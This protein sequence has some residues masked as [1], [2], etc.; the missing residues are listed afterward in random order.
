MPAIS[1]LHR[2]RRPLPGGLG[3]GTSAVSADHLD[4][5]VIAQP[6]GQRR[7]L[8]VGQQ[9][10]RAA[11]VDVDQDGA[12]VMTPAQRE[13]IDAK[14]RQP[15]NRRVGQA[16]QQPYQGIAAGRHTQPTSQS[17]TGSPRQAKRD[18]AQRL[19]QQHRVP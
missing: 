1:H 4:P 17:S 11:G 14:H 8:A 13:V 19:A 9:I 18:H 15:P 12:V 3:V 6:V 2:A 5:G 7:G 10:D 16:A